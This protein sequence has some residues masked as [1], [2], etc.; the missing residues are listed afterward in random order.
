MARQPKNY[1]WQ[2][3]N[4]TKEENHF[5]TYHHFKTKSP[6]AH[7]ITVTS[8]ELNPQLRTEVVL[9]GLIIPNPWLNTRF[10]SAPADHLQSTKHLYP[11]T[12]CTEAVDYLRLT[13]DSKLA[14]AQGSLWV[15][16]SL[17][18]PVWSESTQQ[19][20]SQSKSLAPISPA[21]TLITVART[22]LRGPPNPQSLNTR[23]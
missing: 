22:Q 18:L 7:T 2:K 15:R 21:L 20:C 12:F 3:S 17:E 10:P 16:R 9:E 13:W 4:L 23:F 14:V 8:K 5:F 11:R 19:S 1:S 6:S